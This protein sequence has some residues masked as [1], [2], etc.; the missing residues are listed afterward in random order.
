MENMDVLTAVFDGNNLIDNSKRLPMW[1]PLLSMS[2][3]I[4][5]LMN[6][7]CI[8]FIDAARCNLEY[9]FPRI[10][11]IIGEDLSDVKIRI[12]V[13]S[14]EREVISFALW[15]NGVNVVEINGTMFPANV[16]CCSHN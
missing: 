12:I 5:A 15:Q 3:S 4:F 11:T 6:G 10:G 2:G 8:D 13:I 9:L 1:E 16:V 7:D 14:H